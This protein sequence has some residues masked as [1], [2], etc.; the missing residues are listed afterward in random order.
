MNTLFEPPEE[1]GV[2]LSVSAWQTDV[3][4][5]DKTPSQDGEHNHCH[6]V[7]TPHNITPHLAQLFLLRG[8]V[9]STTRVDE[10]YL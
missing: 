10:D 6:S 7:T 4:S 2:F 3:K 1:A 5:R 9:H 8:K